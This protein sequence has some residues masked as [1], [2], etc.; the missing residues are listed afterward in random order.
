MGKIERNKTNVLFWLKRIGSRVKLAAIAVGC[1]IMLMPFHSH[2]ASNFTYAKK[3]IDGV[4]HYTITG[5]TGSDTN[6]VFPQEIDGNKITAIGHSAFWKRTD[7]TSITI[8]EGYTVID[9]N[10]FYG[11]TNVTKIN[12]PNTLIAIKDYGLNCQQPD[13][14]KVERIVLPKSLQSI[15]YA[16]FHSGLAYGVYANSYGHNWVK[17]SNNYYTIVDAG[18]KSQIPTGKWEGI[19]ATFLDS[20]KGSSREND[21]DKNVM[22]NSYH[23]GEGWINN[24]TYATPDSAFITY[25]SQ[26]DVYMTVRNSANGIFADYFTSNFAFIGQKKIPQELPMFGGFKETEKYYFIVSGQKNH[27]ESNDKEVIRVTKYDK[28]WNRIGSAAVKG[29][30]VYEPFACNSVDMINVNDSLIVRT[31]RTKYRTSDGLNHECSHTF[32]IDINKMS[33]IFADGVSDRGDKFS[34]VSHS[35]NQFAALDNDGNFVMV[36]HG[37]AYP[38]RLQLISRPT[39][40]YNGLLVTGSKLEASAFDIS[41]ATG[42]NTTGVMLGG[43]LATDFSYIVAGTSVVQDKDYRNHTTRN[44][45]VSVIDKKNGASKIKWITNYPDGESPLDTCTNPYLLKVNTDANVIIWTRGGTL[46]YQMLDDAGNTFGETKSRA[47]KLSDCD[48]I[49]VDNKVIWFVANG[50]DNEFF[51]LDLSSE[52]SGHKPNIKQDDKTSPGVSSEQKEMISSFAKRLYTVALSRDYDAAGLEK[53]VDDLASGKK[54]GAEVA[55]GFFFSEEFMNKN[56]SDSD[57]IDTLYRTMF[58]READPNGKADWMKALSSGMSR[59]FV[60]HG[61]AEG[62]E[63][64][65]LCNSYGIIQG[66][67]TLSANRDQNRLLTAFVARNYTKALGRDFDVDGIND[68]TGRILK[69]E[70]TPSDVTAGFIFSPEFMNKNLN[71][72]DFLT[73]LYWTYFDR[74]PDTEGYNMWLERINSNEVNREYVV[75]TGFSCSEEFRN[76]VASFG[77]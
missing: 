37:D 35:F 74:E 59:E 3:Q 38:R 27:E 56:L 42:D 44:V 19:P 11:C 18:S 49:V 24:H 46:Y 61:F 29:C 72:E 12:L 57:Y 20:I 21:F 77:L 1:L 75:K 41:G 15:G 25:D 53:W 17:S 13:V 39:M 23:W 54:T 16:S 62:L 58:N 63:F 40:Y 69:G 47:G 34:Y 4:N 43:L 65:N 36:D 5:Y 64:K 76:L 28:A 31:G 50:T 60:Y 22:Y 9:S 45:F 10:A 48:P 33:V 73:V 8:P 55:Q 66:K 32:E 30:D 52:I 51:T 71:N 6:V 68:W 26:S 7:V 67:V 14:S 70:A 2:A